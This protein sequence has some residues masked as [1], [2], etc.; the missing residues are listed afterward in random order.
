MHRFWHNTYMLGRVVRAFALVAAVFAL[1]TSFG[2]FSAAEEATGA[3]V[4]TPSVSFTFDF[5]AANPSHYVIS[6]GRDGRATYVSDG[7]LGET[8]DRSGSAAADPPLPFVVSD[9]VRE[10]IFDLAQRAHYFSGKVDSGR[11]G[12]ANTGNKTLA[13]KDGQHDSQATYNYSTVA[14]VEQLTAIFQGLSETLEFGRRLSFFHKYQKTA[15]DEDLKRMEELQRENS[16]GDIQ[17]I[18][19]VLKEIAGDQSVMNVARAR[20]L[21]L[22]AAGT[23]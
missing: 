13:Y 20:A 2:Q 21:R 12:I 5:P 11:K 19:P 16:L 15:I 17:A 4:A 3:Q 9:R 6:V 7:Q 23:K 14:P 10:Q 22:M 18:A 8:A 1:N